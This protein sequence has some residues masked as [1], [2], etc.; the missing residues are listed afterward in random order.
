MG[1]HKTNC[2][3]KYHP[4]CPQ[5][6]NI[7]THLEVFQDLWR[8]VRVHKWAGSINYTTCQITDT[9][10]CVPCDADVAGMHRGERTV[11]RLVISWGMEIGWTCELL[12]QA[13]T[14]H[15]MVPIICTGTNVVRCGDEFLRLLC[16]GESFTTIIF[17][18]CVTV[19]CFFFWETYTK[20]KI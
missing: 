20:T 6:R 1:I 19:V 17:E 2:T 10:K 5:L 15:S 13:P 3:K 18:L 11:C 16:R 8:T 12:I 14:I 9:E 4:S 7:S